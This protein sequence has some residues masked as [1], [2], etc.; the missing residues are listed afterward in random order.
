LGCGG[1]NIN[2]AQRGSEEIR[3]TNWVPFF[4]GHA[5]AEILGTNCHQKTW[6]RICPQ[7]NGNQILF[8]VVIERLP[9]SFAW[10]IA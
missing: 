6:K 4:S 8:L 3:G 1:G 5:V 9:T 7:K 2:S 10:R